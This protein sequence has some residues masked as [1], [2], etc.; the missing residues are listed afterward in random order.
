MIM[1]KWWRETV[2]RLHLVTG[3]TVTTHQALIAFAIASI[4][5]NLLFNVG[6]LGG[7][8]L[9]WLVISIVGTG[10]GILALIL[11]RPWLVRPRSATMNSILAFGAVA[12]ASQIKPILVTF[13]SGQSATSSF[14]VL[15]LPGPQGL[16][17]HLLNLITVLLGVCITA[18]LVARTREHKAERAILE[19]ERQR[20]LIAS[21][22]VAE[23]VRA[24]SE[25]LTRETQIVL[26]PALD[27]VR[28]SLE[29]EE[30]DATTDRVIEGLSRVVSDVIRPLSYSYASEGPL[31]ALT[32]GE[33]N[34][35]ASGTAGWLSQRVNVAEAIRPLFIAVGIFAGFLLVTLSFSPSV[36]VVATNFLAIFFT[37]LLLL[38]IKKAW[39]KRWSVMRGL[40]A[41]VTLL[42][43]YFLVFLVTNITFVSLGWL[44]QPQER[45]GL[46]IASR[47]GVAMAISVMVIIHEQRKQVDQSL[48]QVNM[49]IARHVSVLRREVWAIRRRMSM[50]LHGSVQSVLVSA[51]LLL[52]DDSGPQARAEVRSRLDQALFAIDL[53]DKD[54]SVIEH[55]MSEIVTLWSKVA[56]IEITISP[57]CQEN[58]LTDS[59][60]RES[61]LEIVRESVSNAIRHGS[62]NVINVTINPC[63][64]ARIVV[65]ISDNGTGLLNTAEPGLG[66]RMLDEVC[67]TWNQT[68]LSQGVK[69]EAVLA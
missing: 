18:A 67:F 62:A 16:G 1:S 12:L 51:M 65:T 23:R 17:R 60:L 33:N 48:S 30:S 31:A 29:S 32:L 50:V 47:V 37:S 43:T 36:G 13:F 8:F 68:K 19:S 11:A 38:V 25:A 3:D 56:A 9:P 42:V 49:N 10:L 24:E 69:L 4:V 28:G 61:C 26:G 53:D 20:L 40:A 39:P 15:A 64:D 45:S 44:F 22:T 35:E 63:E 52:R 27:A 59:A 66:S 34:A 7:Q 5:P 6:G 57:E 21:I 55:G 54:G 2:A 46:G 14:Y 41:V 58:L